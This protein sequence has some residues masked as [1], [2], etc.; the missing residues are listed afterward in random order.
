MVYHHHESKYINAVKMYSMQLIFTMQLK[1]MISFEKKRHGIA[2]TLTLTDVLARIMHVH[3]HPAQTKLEADLM[4]R[5]DQISA[6]KA[7]NTAK[8]LKD[9]AGFAIEALWHA[10]ESFTSGEH[11]F[12]YRKQSVVV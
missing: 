11:R 2:D 8:W 10:A 1:K 5:I 6:E 12:T 3:E 7:V 9:I 4:S